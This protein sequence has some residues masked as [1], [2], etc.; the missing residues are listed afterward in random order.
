M[1]AALSRLQRVSC[2]TTVTW[3][4]SASAAGRPGATKVYPGTKVVAIE[5]VGV[6]QPLNAVFRLP[7]ISKGTWHNFPPAV[8]CVAQVAARDKTGQLT[9]CAPEEQGAVFG[10][11][12]VANLFGPAF[13]SG[14]TEQVDNALAL[15]LD[16]YQEPLIEAPPAGATLPLDATCHILTGPSEVVE[17]SELQ[18]H[19][20][21][22]SE[23]QAML[24]ESFQ[25]PHD[26]PL[27]LP[28]SLDWRLARLSPVVAV[29]EPPPETPVQKLQNM[30][31]GTARLLGALVLAS[32]L[33]LC[34]PHPAL[35]ARSMGRAGGG[36]F[37]SSRSSAGSSRSSSSSSSRSSS[38]S[39]SRSSSSSSSRSG[40]SGSSRSSSL[41][42]GR[43][44]SSNSGR[45]GSSSSGGSS[46]SSRRS[47]S[48]SGGS[49]GSGFHWGSTPSSHS[50]SHSS[51]SHGHPPTHPN[52]GGHSLSHSDSHAKSGVKP[53]SG[54]AAGK[55]SGKPPEPNPSPSSSEKRRW[56]GGGS[57]EP[58]EPYLNS[59]SHSDTLASIHLHLGG[60]TQPPFSSHPGAYHYSDTHDRLLRA[61]FRSLSG[62]D[63][64]KE[65][66]G[67]Q[68]PGAEVP[69]TP[70]E[71]AAD[72]EAQ[73]ATLEEVLTIL[74]IAAFEILVVTILALGMHR[75]LMVVFERERPSDDN[76]GTV[77]ERDG[78]L[79]ADAS[80]AAERTRDDVSESRAPEGTR[81]YDFDTEVKNLLTVVKIQVALLGQAKS[82]QVQM[83]K[84]CEEADT[85]S[86]EGLHN[87]LTE[88]L[89]VILRHS[90]YWAYGNAQ[91]IPL[92]YDA[93]ERRYQQ[94]ALEER[95]KAE[96]ETLVNKGGK[97]TKMPSVRDTDEEPPPNELIVV[98]VLA[99]VKGRLEAR[100]GAQRVAARESLKGALQALSQVQANDLEVLDILWVPQEDDDTL[101]HAEL[102]EN[103]TDLSPM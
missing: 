46:S 22:L 14:G 85:G 38:S 13:L 42:S 65:T 55:S 87:L 52:T 44:S 67:Q 33:A 12:P 72:A 99:A 11:S 36:G 24:R 91:M 77:R 61:F 10:T 95:S 100:E 20:D 88:T 64:S 34:T 37:S 92:G 27:I 93:A 84:L 51:D 49:S 60:P 5:R 103:F 28:D 41:S 48:S 50:S 78:D 47:S 96:Q 8:R 31:M 23:E 75:I 63:R 4:P 7:V 54:G 1:A 19:I 74:G 98:T 83:D 32:A 2:C 80:R 97:L 81:V 68:Q 15:L 101:T 82:V 89:L 56:F 102:I 35:A 21:A 45:S 79:V 18:A 73:K 76:S 43:S 62:E 30:L 16:S 90:T 59:H 71:A 70:K 26:G 66:G 58:E 86:K 57:H 39:S 53:W 17:D 40:S 25:A 3:Q 9:E 69:R 29:D 6:F 94:I